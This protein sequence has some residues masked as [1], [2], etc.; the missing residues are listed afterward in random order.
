MQKET[1]LEEI[2]RLTLESLQKQEYSTETLL[3]YQ[4][5]FNALNSFAHSRGISEPSDGLFQEY[6][7]DNKN[8]Y[9]GEYS[10][11]KDRQRIRV[12]NLIK[13]YITNGEADTSRRKGKS[14]YDSIQTEQLKKELDR[15]ITILEEEPL[16][17]NT[18][19][20]YKRIVAYLLIYCEKKSYRSIN[21]LVSGDIRN[22][23]LYLYEQ[24]YFKPTTITS[25]LSGLKRFL[26]LHPDIEHFIMEL[27]T[28]LPRERK[29][30]E[31]YSE[32]ETYAINEILSDGSLSKRDKAICLLLLETGLRAVD[33][34]N[35]KLSDIDW[36]KDVIYIKQ[37][38]T[39]MVLNIPL[40]KS[41][42]L[43]HI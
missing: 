6:L 40:R 22:F 17:P 15:F 41:L 31:I 19:Y 13:S 37:Q 43:I 7:S 5:K 36:N 14:A 38:K 33:V 2:L 8:K 34:C 11:F 29:I 1:K 23:I 35:I 9:T 12:V 16:R 10:V 27:P 3:R 26:S 32:T 30:I 25:G 42:S 4:K 21:E 20:T 39:G 18:I 28:R 24:G